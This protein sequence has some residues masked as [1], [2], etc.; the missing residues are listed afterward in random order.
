MAST[1]CPRPRDDG[2]RSDA[3]ISG[4][5]SDFECGWNGRT[6]I[7]GLEVLV[8]VRVPDSPDTSSLTGST[9][10]TLP[11]PCDHRYASDGFMPY[12]T[13]NLDWEG[14]LLSI[15]LGRIQGCTAPFDCA[16]NNRDG[17][18]SRSAHRSVGVLGSTDISWR[19][20]PSR[21]EATREVRCRVRNCGSLAG[22]VE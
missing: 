19:S 2:L 10:P 14:R 4:R 20:R 7:G 18:R 3:R 13:I 12:C 21:L 1:S 9:G 22:G 8:V 16:C 15:V 6:I 17:L 5:R 11:A